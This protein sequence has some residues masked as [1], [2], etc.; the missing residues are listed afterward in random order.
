MQKAPDFTLP[1]QNGTSHTLSDYRGKWV[2]VY[3]YPKDETPGC[4][5]QACS[6]RDGRQ[7]LEDNH[8]TVLGISAD[9]VES[10]K[11]FAD[12]HELN[13]T[14]L[15]DPD[16]KVIQAYDSYKPK[17]MFGKE[18]LGIHRNTFIINPEGEIVKEYTNVKPEGHAFKI[19]Q[20]IR[21]LQNV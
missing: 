13:F 4:T 3:F 17:K 11:K 20:D 14:L 9:S 15:S 10:H 19:I 18:F 16:K 5:A 2:V 1:D 21:E 12:K 6:F 8:I 7:I